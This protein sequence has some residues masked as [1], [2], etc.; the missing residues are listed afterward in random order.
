MS[1]TRSSAASL[2]PQ[3]PRRNSYSTKPGRIYI[4]PTTLSPAKQPNEIR[5]SQL[6][7]KPQL[8]RG[9]RFDTSTG[10]VIRSDSEDD[11]SERNDNVLRHLRSLKSKA[12]VSGDKDKNPEMANDQINKQDG[13]VESKEGRPAGLKRSHTTGGSSTLRQHDKRKPERVPE[14]RHSERRRADHEHDDSDEHQAR[15]R[16][17]RRSIAQDVPHRRRTR[18]PYR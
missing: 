8:V 10:K 14:R 5:V 11:E 9:V 4:I 18:S 16:R 13:K 6:R 1:A 7:T 2:N 3:I 15:L 12:R 17:E